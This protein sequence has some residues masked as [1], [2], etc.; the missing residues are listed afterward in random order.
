MRF[1]IIRHGDPDYTVD[2]LTE[3]GRREAALLSD[4]LAKEPI[5]AVYCSTMGR[6]MQ[7]AQPTLDRLGLT[8]EYTDW[9]REVPYPISWEE[10]PE[11]PYW[12]AYPP[13]ACTKYPEITD[14]EKWKTLP[15]FRDA[16]VAEYLEHV[17][18]EFDVLT[19]KYGYV[20][21][22]MYY[23]ILPDAQDTVVALFCHQGLGTAL[24]AHLMHVSVP[25]LWNTTMTP[26]ASVATVLMERF[27]SDDPV[28]VARI[29]SI[30]DTS[31]LYAG[32]EPISSRGLHH[33]IT[34]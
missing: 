26:T 27:F 34:P 18:A 25:L 16:G 19:A 33:E 29:L 22:G 4:R 7:T 28:A 3:K 2:G 1:I 6:A 17:F 21:N 8:A 31:H 20:R 14:A 9:L 12:F 15:M 5:T 32:N 23:D 10:Y 11:R 30:G 24:L 13:R